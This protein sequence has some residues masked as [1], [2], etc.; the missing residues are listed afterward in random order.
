M[1]AVY[2]ARDERLKRSV[3]LKETLISENDLPRAFEH[4]A[5][6]LANLNHPA[7]PKV[8]D[9]FAE[10]DGQ[11]IIMEFIPGD[12]LGK[13]LEQRGQPFSIT[14]VETWYGQLL[15][16]LEY[17]HAHTI[18]HRDLKP[19][20]LKVKNNNGIVLLDFGLAKGSAG[21]MT[22]HTSNQSVLGYTPIYAPLEQIRGEGTSPSSDLY[23][24]G[25]T[26]YHL[27]TDIAPVDAQKRELSLLKT[28][29]DPLQPLAEVRPDL[30]PQLADMLTQS[31]NLEPQERPVSA[32]A[33]RITS[34]SQVWPGGQPL[35]DPN[36]RVDQREQ[37]T[38]LADH[39]TQQV[40]KST[41]SDVEPLPPPPKAPIS[42]PVKLSLG[43]PAALV[44]ILL[45]WFAVTHISSNRTTVVATPSSITTLPLTTANKSSYGGIEI[46]SKGIKAIA[47]KVDASKE[48]YET[49]ALMPLKTVNTTLMSGVAQTGKFS[50]EA[51][52][53][54][55]KAVKNLYTQMRDQYGVATERIHIIGS[56]G[57][58]K[59]DSS[60]VDNKDELVKKIESATGARMSFLDAEHEVLYTISGTIPSQYLSTGILVDIGSGNTKGG[61]QEGNQGD[62][63]VTMSIPFGTVSFTDEI[64]K[65]GGKGDNFSQQA[66]RLRGEVLLPA[67]RQELG[68][69]PGLVN[70]RRVYLSGGIVWAMTT[71]LHPANRDA[72]VKITAEDISTFANRAL[73][74]DKSLLNPTLSGIAD[75]KTRQEVEQEKEQII[76]S[77][78]PH[79]LIAGAELL[80][81]VYSEFKLSDKEVSFSRYNSMGWGWLLTY[82][83]SQ[84]GEVEKSNDQGQ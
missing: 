28:G 8:F 65:Q 34:S 67:L 32:S 21:H 70:R 40:D 54:T 16:A 46:G 23:S 10:N 13:L 78:S 17:L 7:L 44:L 3:A 31:L 57:L 30:P 11:Y 43:I 74:G 37:P 83:K 45:V 56:S 79:N 42:R 4:E 62:R 73:S 59:P 80:Q 36:P 60:D 68:R 33:M 72:D 35:K 24:L 20:N 81:A 22:R 38:V 82:V 26:M 61:Y 19:A 6:L 53:D 5:T 55:A 15:D 12:D 25:A 58:K 76:D 39:P 63:F 18:I 84:P 27:L 1:G 51:I 69:K 52:D 77:F 66:E 2:E 75:A 48:G 14:Q 49:K 47:L 41:L 50:P 64:T 71:L 29:R 9:H